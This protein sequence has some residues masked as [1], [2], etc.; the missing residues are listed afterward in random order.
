MHSKRHFPNVIFGASLRPQ[1]AALAIMLLLLFLIFVLLFMTLAAQ[2]AQAQTF[3][4]LHQFTGGPDGAS[5]WAGLTIDARGDL[6]GTTYGGGGGWGTVFRL[7]HRGSSWVLNPICR[8]QGGT[9]GGA[10]FARVNFGPDGSLYGT[11]TTEAKDQ[12]MHRSV[13][14]HGCGTVFKVSP[15]DSL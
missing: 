12:R 15:R 14:P 9:D 5:P 3:N 1:G 8:F 4:A 2:P 10:P 11:T 13:L 6:Y 7:S